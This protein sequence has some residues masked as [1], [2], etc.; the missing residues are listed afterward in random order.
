M[1]QIKV[2]GKYT[3]CRKLGAGSF[4][5]LYQGYDCKTNEE[6]AIKLEHL[7][8]EQPMLQYEATLCKRMQGYPGFS[9][10]HWMGVDGEFYALVMDLLGPSLQNLYDFCGRHFGMKTLLWVASEMIQRVETM[11]SKNFIHRDIK[12]ENFLIGHGKK[13]NIIYMIDFGLSKRYRCPKTGQH[14]DFKMRLSPTGTLRYCSLMA[15]QSYEQSRRDDLES[16][17]NILMYF[18]NGGHLPWMDL[19]EK[20]MLKQVES[21]EHID[22]DEYLKDQPPCFLTYMKYVRALQFE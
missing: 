3:I 17:G 6:V 8:S 2:G 10:I 9:N 13:L 15:H 5:I 11:H 19:E 22:F 20:S 14:I 4:G 12:P 7:D 16:V 18:L 1:Q 21:K